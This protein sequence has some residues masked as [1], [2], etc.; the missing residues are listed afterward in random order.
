MSKKEAH[1]DALLHAAHCHGPRAAYH[2]YFHYFNTQKFYDAPAALES[3]CLQERDGPNNTFFKPLTHLAGASAHLKKN[4]L[5]PAAALLRLSRSYLETYPA[6]HQ[7]LNLINVLALID[8]WL[9][10]LQQGRANPLGK[11]AAPHLDLSRKS[12]L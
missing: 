4:R 8:Y 7:D 10:L 9:N 5:K 1:I 12:I 11:H 6:L 3:L 2:A